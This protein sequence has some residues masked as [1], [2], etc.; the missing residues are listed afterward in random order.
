MTLKQLRY[1]TVVAETGN[2]TEAAKKLFIAQPSLTASIQELEKEYDITI[3]HR[4]KRGIEITPEGEEFLGYARQVLEQTNLIE[5]RYS[6]GNTGKHRFSVSSQH[7]SFVVESFVELLK[8]VGGDKYEFHMRETETYDIIK[9]VAN[10]RSEI[11]ILY[12]NEFNET[13]I[14]KTLRDN[15]LSFTSLLKVKPHVF[16]GRKSPLAGKKSISLEDLKEYPRLSYEQGSHN[17]FY[18]SEEILSTVDSDREIIVRDRASLFNMLIGMNGYTICSGIISEE[19]NGPNII[20]KPLEVED[21]MDI[22][23]ILPKAIRP[24]ALTLDY[25]DILNRTIRSQ[26]R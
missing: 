7:Y 9:D 2:I 5:E 24:S 14:N 8:K 25:I 21:Y 6:S 3:F 26:D 16:I 18:F 17:S 10:L 19:L 20:A 4:S 1:I 23:Y 15:N 22:G 12:I 13:V 11:G